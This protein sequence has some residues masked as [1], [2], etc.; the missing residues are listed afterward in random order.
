MDTRWQYCRMCYLV[1][2]FKILLDIVKVEWSRIYFCEIESTNEIVIF[3]RYQGYLSYIKYQF[4]VVQI[5]SCYIKSSNLDT[6]KV[7]NLN[8]RK[9]KKKQ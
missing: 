9:T 4:C 6:V 1:A 2:S 8:N 7:H 5:F 3:Q